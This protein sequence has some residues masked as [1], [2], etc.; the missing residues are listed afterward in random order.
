M[1]CYSTVKILGNF[2]CFCCLLT[3]FVSSLLW[4]DMVMV[5]V[6]GYT[7]KA[8]CCGCHLVQFVKCIVWK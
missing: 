2:V 7:D 5:N 8:E 3:L 6:E 4:S 1:K